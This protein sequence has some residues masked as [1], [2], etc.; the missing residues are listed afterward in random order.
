[1]NDIPPPRL[2]ARLDIKGSNVIKGIH[3]EGLRV[4]GQPGPM[5]RLY[6]E[7]GVDEII[8]MD[9]V[10]SLYGRNNILPVVE[11]AARDIFVPLTVGGGIRTIDD[12]TA[13]LRSGADKVAINT[14]AIARPDFLREAAE[15]F[16]S[17]CITLSIEAKRR[18]EGRWEALTDNGRERTGVD[19][20]AW[21]VEAERLGAGEV[22]VTSVDKEGTRRGERTVVIVEQA[23]AGD[24]VEPVVAHGGDH[25]V[26]RP[27]A[28]A[29][30]HRDGDPLAHRL[31]QLVVEAAPRAF[32]VDG[33]HQHL[34][35]PQ[36]LRL[37]HP[38]ED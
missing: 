24:G 1:M 19:V 9:T 36:P 3:L 7:Q 34:A 35:G 32:L 20:L 22:L 10:A 8:Y 25:M 13:A 15:T 31:E 6:Y 28:A 17:Q 2:I 4:V 27:R 37:Y 14:A 29:A 33:G 38:R 11:E 12:I 21:V 18:G 23:G 26:G 16:G 5:A 30:D